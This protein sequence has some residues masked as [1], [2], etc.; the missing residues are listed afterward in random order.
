MVALETLSIEIE[1]WHDQKP[2]HPIKPE[3]LLDVEYKR[4]AAEAD[5]NNFIEECLETGEW[6]DYRLGE[7]RVLATQAYL[8]LLNYRDLW[9]NGDTHT[10]LEIEAVYREGAEL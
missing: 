8:R 10:V 9:L 7:L 3:W 2:T 4:R 1:T 5:Y 6:D